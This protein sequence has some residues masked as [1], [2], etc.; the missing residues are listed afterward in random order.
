[1]NTAA[2]FK[3]WLDKAEA[4]QELS[5]KTGTKLCSADALRCALDRGVRFVV[6][7][8]TG[9]KDL[10]SRPMDPGLWELMLKGTALSGAH[11]RLVYY[12]SWYS[13][14]TYHGK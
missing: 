5:E 13:Y 4:A 1:M 6:Y 9:T 11:R 2:Q 12:L 7:V 10:Q 8:P 14:I 3:S